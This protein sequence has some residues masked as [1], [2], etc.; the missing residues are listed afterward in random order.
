MSRSMKRPINSA[1]AMKRTPRGRWRRRP[2]NRPDNSRGSLATRMSGPFLRKLRASTASGVN[3][4]PCPEKAPP[5]QSHAQRQERIAGARRRKPRQRRKSQKGSSTRRQ[6]AS[7]AVRRILRAS[8]ISPHG[9]RTICH[10]LSPP[11]PSSPLVEIGFPARRILPRILEDR[12]GGR[13]DYV[14]QTHRQVYGKRVDCLFQ[15][16]SSAPAS[17]RVSARHERAASFPRGS[18]VPNTTTFPL[19]MPDRNRSHPPV[20]AG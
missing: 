14:S 2:N 5:P 17:S 20:P 4:S 19:R 10:P 13:Q 15:R 12:P 8:G 6:N 7:E 16:P 1:L 11:L 9:M 3:A 18:A